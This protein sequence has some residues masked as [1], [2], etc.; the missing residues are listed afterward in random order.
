MSSVA[1]KFGMS[2]LLPNE[3]TVIYP[4][5][6]HQHHVESEFSSHSQLYHPQQQPQKQQ[7]NKNN[8]QQQFSAHNH[9]EQQNYNYLPYQK[10][11]AYQQQ[12]KSLP[13][14]IKMETTSSDNCTSMPVLINNR[15]GK[16]ITINQPT[17]FI[18]IYSS[19]YHVYFLIL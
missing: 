8:N 14:S 18:F 3:A 7:R 13:T 11:R 19:L 4:T 17:K 12:K 2:H 5:G 6:Q 16:I 9:P 10:Q 15:V 1:R